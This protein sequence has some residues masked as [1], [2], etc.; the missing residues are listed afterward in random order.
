[1]TI[2][3]PGPLVRPPPF[4]AAGVTRRR[5]LKSGLALTGV[6]GLV[7]PGTAAY[8]AAEAANGLSVTD[9]RAGAAGLA[10]RA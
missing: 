6:A 9:Y 1:M 7:M 10:G 8:A 2:N 4:P 3:A 5:L